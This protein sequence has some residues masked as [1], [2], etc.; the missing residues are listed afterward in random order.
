MDNCSLSVL[1]YLSKGGEAA[2][3]NP[4]SR[5]AVD[6]ASSAELGEEWAKNLTRASSFLFYFSLSFFANMLA[7]MA[8]IW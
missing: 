5:G 3:L 8:E 1:V 4:P 2:K 6:I 7:S